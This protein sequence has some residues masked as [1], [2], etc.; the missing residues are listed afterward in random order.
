MRKLEDWL[1]HPKGRYVFYGGGGG[2]SRGILEIF[3]EKSRGPP[4]SQN[5]LMWPFTNAYTKTSDPAPTSSKTKITG[6]ENN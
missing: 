5:G 6:S 1:T 3:C 2:V 4:I